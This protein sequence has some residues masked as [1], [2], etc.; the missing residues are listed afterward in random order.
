MDN[1]A[2]EYG[3]SNLTLPHDVVLLPSQGMFY[4]NKKKSV[5]VGYLTASDENILL[6]GG[7]DVTT[8]LIRNKLY[9]PDLRVEDLM[10]SDV[11]AILIFLRNTSFGPELN[12]NLVDP[13]TNKPF[14]TTVSLESLPMKQGMS[15]NEDG[16]FTTQLPKTGVTVKL[17]LLTYG[18]VREMNDMADSYPK[19]M[20]PPKVTWRLT[21]QICEANGTTDKGE[22]AKFVEQLPIADSKY[23]K[24]FLNENEPKLD[25]SKTVKA[26]SGELLTINVGFGAEFFRPFF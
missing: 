1:Q 17:K 14:S 3:Q 22:I 24:N 11:E 25:M 7:A 16:T 26:P 8:N 15:P 9:E 13:K 12:V 10:E 5:K 23:I 19:G 21:R 2:R 20:V 6:A 18:E 4:K